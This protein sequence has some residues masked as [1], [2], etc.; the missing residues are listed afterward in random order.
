M[1]TK[2]C[3]KCNAVLF[4][5]EPFKTTQQAIIEF[6]QNSSLGDAEKQA[7]L[8]DKWI[9][10]GV[11]CLSGCTAIL[12]EVFVRLPEMTTS[13]SLAIAAE[14]A[15][16]HFQEF[17]QMH[18]ATSRIVACVNCG[19][20]G[21]ATLEGESKTALYRQRQ[22]RLLRDRHILSAHCA[23]ERIQLLNRAWWYDVGEGQPECE[24]FEYDRLFKW[25]Y[26]DVTG[27]SEYPDASEATFSK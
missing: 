10:L 6:A 21:G 13:K 27:W 20:F 7:I 23:D 1:S 2:R 12:Y 4:E 26:K 3:Q 25:V 5:A 16:K 15:R 24:Y 9:H 22:H 17:I 11:Y 18:G 14:Y 8:R 19:K